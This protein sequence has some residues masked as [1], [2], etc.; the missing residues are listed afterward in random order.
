M[1]TN[2]V[3]DTPFSGKETRAEKRRKKIDASFKALCDNVYYLPDLNARM[4]YPCILY[5]RSGGAT[6]FANNDPYSFCFRYKVTVI[7]KDPDDRLV[8]RLASTLRGCSFDRAYQSGNLYH[9]V[10]T[11]Y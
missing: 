5:E 7:S 3:P 11:L 10:F 6:D 9:S 2:R 1:A 4:E 8:E